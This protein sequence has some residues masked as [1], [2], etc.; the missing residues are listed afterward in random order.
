M[1]SR[2]LGG[3]LRKLRV[4]AGKKVQDAAEALECGQPKISQIENGRRGIR[5]LDLTTLLNL[6]GVDDEQQRSAIRRLAKEIHKVDWWSGDA[7]MLHDA[8][9]DYLTLEADSTL[10][11]AYEPNVLP[12]QLQIEPYMRQVFSA[13]MPEDETQHMIETRQKRQELLGDLLGFRLRTI[14]DVTALHRIGGSREVVHEQLDHLLVLGKRRNV[15]IQILPLDAAVP[16]EQYAP[17]NIL[18]LKG[19]PPVDVVWLEH[20][21]GG[22]LLEQRPDVRAYSKAWDELTAAAMSPAASQQYIRDLIKES[23]S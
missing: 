10:V 1:R 12:G 9:R 2:R 16:P 5:P 6:Y 23:G 18:T 11:R 4:A 13:T 7:P 22:T 21:T 19:E 17:F 3:E 14:I 8:L 15:H 20:I